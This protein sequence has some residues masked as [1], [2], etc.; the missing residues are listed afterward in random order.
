MGQELKTLS[1]PQNNTSPIRF[2]GS[3]YLLSRSV[4]TASISF[5]VAS[6]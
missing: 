4:D 2:N 6:D 3:P 5:P 1:V